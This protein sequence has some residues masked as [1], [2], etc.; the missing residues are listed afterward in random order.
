LPPQ[1]GGDAIGEQNYVGRSLSLTEQEVHFAPP[2]PE[3]LSELMPAFSRRVAA[4]SGFACASGGGRR[5]HRVS[6]SFFLHPFLG[7]QRAIAPL[8]DPLCFSPV[9]A[10]H[11]RA[12][13]F[14]VSATML[15]RPRDY[16]ASLEAFSKPLMPLVEYSLDP[17]GKMTVL[18]DTR[19]FYRYVDCTFMAESLFGFVEETLEK[20]PAH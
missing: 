7:R 4:D 10:L 19:G 1:G 14:P 13:F 3:D 18:N 5:R 2:K 16:D 11:R 12:S 6:V 15:H 20:R 17:Q 8:P 9:F